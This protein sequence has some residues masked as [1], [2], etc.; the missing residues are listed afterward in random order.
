MTLEALRQAIHQSPDIAGEEG[1]TREKI[2]AFLADTQPTNMVEVGKTGLLVA[3]D[4]GQ[5]GPTLL[6]RAELDGLP[7]QEQNNH[8]PYQSSKPQRGHMCGHDGH[9][10]MVAGVGKA[11]QDKPLSKG[12]VVLLFQPAEETGE[13]AQWVLDD[14]AFEAFHPDGAVALHNVP[15]YPLGSI[16]VREG[17]FTPSVESVT[18]TLDGKTAHAAEPE[19]GQ[20]PAWAI[21]EIL[22]L[23][24][25]LKNLNPNDEAYRL[26]TPVEIQIGEK[27][28]GTAAGHGTISFTL[29]AWTKDQF[30]ALKERFVKKVTHIC[31]Q[32]ALQ[33][34]WQWVEPF[35]TT[36]NDK[37]MTQIFRDTANA[38][39]LEVIEKEMPFR[40]GED[41][42]R[43]TQTFSGAMFGLGSGV[44]QP[45]LHNPDFDFP[46]ALLPIGVQ[47]Y[48]GIIN[49]FIM[50]A[51]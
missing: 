5:A 17:I 18:I 45:A 44:D 14:P 23:A 39:Q 15:G 20:N 48:M 50:T 11:L 29:R 32:H 13:G 16:V 24:A 38:L 28:F 34:R 40:W 2:R 26:V 47:M 41:F 30:N 8:L 33:H 7:I 3:Y 36:R 4:S 35:Y 12:R 19:T 51:S 31:E 22:A 42:G 43:F 10:T 37:A 27:A 1:A 46:D 6:I 9:M 49:R 21:Q 25:E